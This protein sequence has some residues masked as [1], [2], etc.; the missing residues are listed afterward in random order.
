MCTAAGTQPALT[1]SAEK[2]N[3]IKNLTHAAKES[4]PGNLFGD[5]LVPAHLKA[6]WK[7]PDLQIQPKPHGSRRGVVFWAGDEASRNL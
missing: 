5:I 2:I 6:N 3:N 1:F 7:I 4:S